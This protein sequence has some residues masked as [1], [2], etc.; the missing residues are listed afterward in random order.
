MSEEAAQSLSLAAY[1]R[2]LKSN[3]DFRLLWLS[4]VVSEIG[5][6]LYA[7]TVYALLLDL[8]GTAESVGFAVVLQLIPQVFVSP[9]AGVLNDRL[10]RRYVMIFADVARV[11]IVLAMIFVDSASMVWL[12]YLVLTLETVMW[13]LFEP[14]RSAIIPTLAPE[15][16]EQLVANALS[17]VTWSVNLAFGA[18]LGGAIAL[19]F[20]RDAVFLI[21]AATF[22]VSAFLLMGIRARERH[23]ERLPPFHLRDLIDFKPVL[24]GLNYVRHDGRRLATMLVKAGMGLMGAHWVI[25]PIFGDRVFRVADSAT[26]GMSVLFM[27]RGVGSLIGSFSTGIWAKNDERRMR[28]GIFWAFLI[29]GASYVV[30]SGAPTLTI[31]ALAVMAGHAGS[32]QA[33][34]FSTTMLQRTT[35]DRFRGR[36]FSADFAGLFLMMSA[37]SYV[38]SHLIDGGVNVRTIALATGLV[39]LIPALLW[40][41]AQRLWSDGRTPPPAGAVQSD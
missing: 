11:F 14:G 37:V 31:A 8:T 27:A 41:R 18:G 33:W 26:A 24:E 9:A 13:S 21:D 22:V 35:E 36:V 30:L 10:P 32:S 39:S 15:P 23:A 4:Q 16:Q 25:L 17:S 38:A 3:R 2:L 5:D 40:W 28:Q 29:A 34:V 1:G 20:G 19:H 7:V 12:A 6:W